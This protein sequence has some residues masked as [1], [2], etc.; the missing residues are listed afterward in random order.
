LNTRILIGTT[1]SVI[2][3]GMIWASAALGQDV[4]TFVTDQAYVKPNFSAE[5]EAYLRELAKATGGLEFDDAMERPTCQWRTR[6]KTAHGRVEGSSTGWF[7]YMRIPVLASGTTMRNVSLYRPGFPEVAYLELKGKW[8][9]MSPDKPVQWTGRLS[10]PPLRSPGSEIGPMFEVAR[11]TLAGHDFVTP[12]VESLPRLQTEVPLPAFGRLLEAWDG[13]GG[14][15]AELSLLVPA[16][17]PQAPYIR[18]QAKWPHL[19][20]DIRS[21]EKRIRDAYAR[22]QARQC[23]VYS[24]DCRDGECG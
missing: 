22:N 7:S 18:L 21:A 5:D 11:V 14:L 19:L 15:D 23:N 20:D 2:A 6:T 16:N 12:K 3:L 13:I 24:R 1:T 4:G 8:D 17:D 9:P 10:V